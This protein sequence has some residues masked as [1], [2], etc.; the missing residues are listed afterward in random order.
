LRVLSDKSA[1]AKRLARRRFTGRC[2]GWDG[3]LLAAGSAGTNPTKECVMPFQSTCWPNDPDYLDGRKE[4]RLPSS[5]LLQAYWDADILDTNGV[6]PGDIIDC[7]DP[8]QVR[9]R[10]E[11]SGG[12]WSCMAGDWVFEL[13]FTEIGGTGSGFDLSSK[14]PPG[15]L[16][17]KNWK[18]CETL[19]IELLVNVPAYTI[20]PAL[21]ETGARFQLYCCDKPAKVTGY[22]ALE[23][24]QFYVP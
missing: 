6:D 3:H 17:V 14:L 13:G 9:Y 23:E 7:S 12:A 19:C 2:Q 4:L 18:G 1:A 10:V 15:A 22:E 5:A 8:F 21:Y 24:R 16:T 20:P 11:L